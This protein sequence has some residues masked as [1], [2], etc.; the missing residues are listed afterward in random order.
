MKQLKK[1]FFL[2]AIFTLFTLPLVSPVFSAGAK[3]QNWSEEKLTDKSK[4]D[5]DK[6]ILYATGL[7]A[8]DSKK[9]NDAKAYLRAYN[10]AK[11]DAIANLLMAVEHV[12]IDA[13][14]T[15]KDFEADTEIKAEIKGIVKGAQVVAERKITV[16]NGTMV[17]VTVAL[18]RIVSTRR[19]RN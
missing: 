19:G 12:K 4:L 10:Y 3:K 14:T 15:G 6:G 5:W 9:G 7:G 11:Y 1:V 8:I 16:G 13:Q 18:G 17:E 2:G